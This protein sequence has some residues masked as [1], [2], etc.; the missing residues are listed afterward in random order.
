MSLYLDRAAKQLAADGFPVTDDLLTRL[1]P[2]QFDHINSWAATPS[3]ARPKPAAG[4]CGGRL[5]ARRT[6]SCKSRFAPGLGSSADRWVW[7]DELLY[8]ATGS[9]P[10][11]AHKTTTLAWLS[12][13]HASHHR[14]DARHRDDD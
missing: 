4:R 12:P 7:I 1:S 9:R 3:S 14:V 13:V 10:G 6:V 11:T 8:R 5:R 2:L